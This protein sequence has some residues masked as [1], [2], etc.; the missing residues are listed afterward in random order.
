MNPYT[1]RPGPLAGLTLWAAFQFSEVATRRPS[2]TG[3][4]SACDSH[5]RHAQEMQRR[6]KR[7]GARG[8]QVTANQDLGHSEEK[9]ICL[10][11]HSLSVSRA[12]P[13]EQTRGRAFHG[14]LQ[15]GLELKQYG[16]SPSAP[17]HTPSRSYP[18]LE[19]STSEWVN[20]RMRRGE[21]EKQALFYYS[22][23]HLDLFKGSEKMLQLYLTLHLKVHLHTE[24]Y[25]ESTVDSE[26]SN[27][28]AGNM[29]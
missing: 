5:H 4:V 11:C 24:V 2:T 14:I 8:P 3:P 23:S 22:Q 7:N 12:V 19:E 17:H 26:V 20:G 18:V 25:T 6:A 13:R 28:L 10:Q 21:R 9:D 27:W 1:A 15:D 16:P 29:P